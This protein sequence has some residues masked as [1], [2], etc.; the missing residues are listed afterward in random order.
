MDRGER[1]EAQLALRISTSPLMLTVHFPRQRDSV[2]APSPG[3]APISPFMRPG[4]TAAPVLVLP[5]PIRAA[6][7]MK[8]LWY[9]SHSGVSGSNTRNSFERSFGQW[10]ANADA[11][12]RVL[13]DDAE[14]VMD[15]APGTS[16]F[17]QAETVEF[18]G[19]HYRVVAVAPIA[20]GWRRP[21]TLH[22]GL[23]GD[24]G[25]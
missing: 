6:K 8:C 25:G 24:V 17:H 19:I 4:P 23:R 20:A 3:S 16:V 18:Q 10:V 12:A 11:I 15:A 14:L 5:D 21:T 2:S 7:T 9:A 22:V 1:I 13:A